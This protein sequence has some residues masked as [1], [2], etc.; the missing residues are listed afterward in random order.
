MCL[1]CGH[2]ATREMS[3]G[4]SRD[5]QQLRAWNR[6]ARREQASHDIRKPDEIRSLQRNLYD[7]NCQPWV[8]RCPPLF[9]RPGPIAASAC[10]STQL[11]HAICAAEMQEGR[12]A[13]DDRVRTHALGLQYCSA[14][15]S[16]YG[17]NCCPRSWN[18]EAGKQDTKSFKKL[19]LDFACLCR[20][21]A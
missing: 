4:T 8:C 18:T 7:H 21:V 10:Q 3:H 19:L 12:A 14:I 5:M 2:N 6:V 9:G 16:K 1:P 11:S 20:A 13:H 17:F 15:Q